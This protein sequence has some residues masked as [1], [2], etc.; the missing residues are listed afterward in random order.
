MAGLLFNSDGGSGA[1]YA[2]EPPITPNQLCRVINSLEGTGVDTFI[3]SVSMVGF[4][5]YGT[6]IGE[7]YGKGMVEFENENFRRL[8]QNV[9]GLLDE[10]KDPLEIWSARTH[11]LGMNFWPSL[12]MNDIHKDWVERWP[13]LRT[14]WELERPHLAIGKAMPDRYR[15]RYPNHTFTWALDYAQKEVREYKFAL[16]DEICRNY[17]VD[18]LEMDFLSHPIYFKQNEEASGATLLTEFVRQVRKRMD[19]IGE[20]KGKKLTLCA[21]VLPDIKT[22]EKIGIDILSWIEE[23]LVDVIAPST[24]GCLDVSAD[25]RNFVAQA[26]ESSCIIAGSI[27]DIMVS[28]YQKKEPPRASIEMMRATTA[29]LWHQGVECIHLF[30]FDCGA[31]GIQHHNTVDSLIDAETLPLFSEE[32]YTILTEIGAPEKIKRK[33]KHYY[34]TCDMSDLTVEEGG[35]MQLPS[36]IA[37][38]SDPKTFQ[39]II[40]DKLESVQKNKSLKAINLVITLEKTAQIPSSND[41]TFRLNNHPL[42]LRTEGNTLLSNDPPFRKG[43]NQLEIGLKDA[44]A[45]EQIRING[46]ELLIQFRSE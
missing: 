35:E 13:S 2:F 45:T 42:A 39:L 21:R 28:Q 14:R 29:A 23:E 4:V 22:C 36:L 32:E 9:I 44:A 7:L 34:I 1:L 43:A 20:Q 8:A 3:Q 27:S 6:K 16:I 38:G 12:R 15:N 26:K 41:I 18:G 33:D 5:T 17:D 25:I 31:T 30:N 46:I 24:R 11:E 19:E 37:R 10:G 40:G